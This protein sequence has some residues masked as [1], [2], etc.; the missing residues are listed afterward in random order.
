MLECAA[1]E[2]ELELE[3]VPLACEVL[4]ELLGDRGEQ[5]GPAIL[6]G[7]IAC[8][9]GEGQSRQAVLARNSRVS[10]PSGLS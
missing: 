2:L 10:G 8:A 6:L 4:L 9:A 3:A 7:E 5:L 1:D